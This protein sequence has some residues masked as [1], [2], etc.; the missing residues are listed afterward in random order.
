M[1]LEDN[2]LAVVMRVMHEV[3]NNRPLRLDEADVYVTVSDYLM[4]KNINWRDILGK[5]GGD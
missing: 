5:E 1:D 3:W 2:K 4:S